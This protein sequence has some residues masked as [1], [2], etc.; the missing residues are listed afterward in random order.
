MQYTSQE[1]A[2]ISQALQIIESKMVHGDQI[3]SPA[4]ALNLLKLK[5]GTLEHE[6]F[7]VIFLNTQQ[8]IISSEIMFR[9]TVN[10]APVYPREVAKRALELNAASVILGHNHPSGHPF[11]SQADKTIT[12]ALVN[13]LELFQIKVL[14]HIIV[15]QG[16]SFSFMESGLL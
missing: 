9:G 14:D 1:K 6:V 10:A 8:T 11:P 7:A 13:A 15:A 2:I 5:I 12:V 3:N 4:Q 16:A